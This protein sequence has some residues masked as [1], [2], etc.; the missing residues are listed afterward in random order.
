MASYLSFQEFKS[1]IEYNKIEINIEELNITK[2]K[3]EKLSPIAYS[4]NSDITILLF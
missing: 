2:F 1:F 4:E 3:I